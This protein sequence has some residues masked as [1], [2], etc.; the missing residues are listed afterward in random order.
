[1]VIFLQVDENWAIFVERNEVKWDFG[2]QNPE[3]HEVVL[4]FITGLANLGEDLFGEQG[5]AS[6]N[7]DLRKHSGLKAAEV[8]IVSLYDQ[9][10]LL[11]S[12]PITTLRL[13]PYQGGI[14]N[15]VKEIMTA[16]LV[17]GASIL[18]GT[19][20]AET[21]HII[22]Q[23]I[24]EKFRNII[25]DINPGYLENDLIYTIVGKSGCNFSILSFEECLLLHCY[26][27][28]QADQTTYAP[29]SNWC[30]ISYQDGG[31]VPFSFQ[32]EDEILYGGYF[33]A[34]IGFIS[35]LFESKPKSIIFGTTKIRKLRFVYGTKYFMAIDTSFMIDL[36]LK[37]QFQQQ[38]FDTRYEILK[39]LASGIKELIIEEILEFNEEKL[40]SLT[41]E[42]LLDTYI[43]EG[44]ENLTLFL[45]SDESEDEELLREE[46][47]NQVLRV[48]GRFLINL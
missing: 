35:T 12:D 40:N 17:G 42:S 36:L 27:R 8:L 31:D 3:F 45:G 11:I 14:P 19:S 30:L 39:D 23:K 28:K 10:F 7:F 5:I 47:K 34:I 26:L 9:F 6:I 32:I 29:T 16:V 43:G 1:M 4:N 33:A 41:A 25:L 21:D 46:H 44:S 15:D 2:I 37:R 18:Y 20:I 48:W 38:F 22:K 24:N 13:I